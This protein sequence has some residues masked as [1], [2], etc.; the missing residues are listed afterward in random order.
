MYRS[1]PHS[2]TGVSLA[3]MLFGRKIKT[4]MPEIVGERVLD[5]ETREGDAWNKVKGK[6]Y[7]DEKKRVK[8][9]EIE[10]GDVVLL[11]QQ[12]KSPKKNKLSPNYEDTKFVVTDKKNNAVTITSPEV[13]SYKRNASL[14]KKFCD[15]G[16]RED[17]GEIREGENNEL[18]KES[19]E[20]E[21][22]NIERNASSGSPKTIENNRPKREIRVPK[23]FYNF[24][25]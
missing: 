21:N 15:K 16:D 13:V 12:L 4:K 18:E 10:P 17:S 25:M 24:V 23:H 19:S 3:E 7:Y 6:E 11:K 1:T 9:T 20:V 5:E 2:T 14:V 8:E 22:K